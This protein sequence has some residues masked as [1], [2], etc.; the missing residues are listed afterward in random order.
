MADEENQ[1]KNVYTTGSNDNKD[2]Q[3]ITQVAD[4]VTDELKDT[5]EGAE[6]GDVGDE[7]LEG[8]EEI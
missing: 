5:Q 3:H 7:L 8:L 6:E 1:I 2:A 4:K